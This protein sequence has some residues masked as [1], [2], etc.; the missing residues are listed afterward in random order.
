[1]KAGKRA[2]TISTCVTF[3]VLELENITGVMRKGVAPPG[4]WDSDDGIEL[5]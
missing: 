4:A 1:M 5:E 2:V 3:Q